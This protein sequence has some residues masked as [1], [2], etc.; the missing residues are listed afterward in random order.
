MIRANT[1]KAIQKGA[2]SFRCEVR[3]LAKT[4]RCE[5]RLARLYCLYSFFS[6]LIKLGLGVYHLEARFLFT[7]LGQSWRDLRLLAIAGDEGRGGKP[8][9][10]GWHLARFFLHSQGRQASHWLV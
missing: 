10:P 2:E 1:E 5:V 8:F 6:Q 9:Y 3:K 4:F 7:L